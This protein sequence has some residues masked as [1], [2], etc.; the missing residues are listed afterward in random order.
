[1]TSE[2]I[3]ANP[4]SVARNEFFMFFEETTQLGMLPCL[5]FCFNRRRF[6]VLS[7]FVVSIA[8]TRGVLEAKDTLAAKIVRMEDEIK[9]LTKRAEAALEADDEAAA[10]AFL[11]KKQ[12]GGAAWPWRCSE[13]CLSA[14]VFP[15][16]PDVFLIHIW[17]NA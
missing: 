3:L 10:R 14:D 9:D 12:L 8:D 16:F 15:W 13:H 2:L 5:C 4:P 1:M 11:E 7:S 6:H 17:W